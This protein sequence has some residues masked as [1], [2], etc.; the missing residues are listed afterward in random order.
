MLEREVEIR[1]PGRENR[2]DEFVGEIGWVE[3]EKPDSLDEFSNLT[4]EGNDRTLA[5]SLIPT[6]RSEILCNED[7]LGDFELLYLVENRVM[8]ARSLRAPEGGNCTKPTVAIAPLRDLHV[9]PWPTRRRTW[10]IEQIECRDCRLG[11][12]TQG[13]RHTEPGYATT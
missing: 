8:G 10:E 1:D 6:E 7:D 3:V 13:D 11:S 2:I 5:G 9:G 4:N 12:A